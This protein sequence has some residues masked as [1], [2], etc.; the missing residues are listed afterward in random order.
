MEFEAFD[1]TSYENQTHESSKVSS[2]GLYNKASQTCWPYQYI[3]CCTS[4]YCVHTLNT[5]NIC[6]NL[7]NLNIST[8]ETSSNKIKLP[9]VVPNAIIPVP[10]GAWPNKRSF[11]KN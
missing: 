4:I 1:I 8:K 11:L 6:S 5:K 9:K 10:M 2:M 7:N 3:R